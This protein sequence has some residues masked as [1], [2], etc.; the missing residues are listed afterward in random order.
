MKSRVQGAPTAAVWLV[1]LFASDRQLESICGDLS[2]EFSDRLAR[3]GSAAAR[4]WYW[5]QSI[6]T[7]GDLIVAGLR[8]SPVLITLSVLA[9]LA[10]LGFSIPMPERIIDAVIHYFQHGVISAPSN[11]DLFWLNTGILAGRFLVAVLVGGMIAWISAGKEVIVGLSLG[12]IWALATTIA[13]GSWIIRFWPGTTI[14]L[15]LAEW[16]IEKNLLLIA[17]AVVTGSIIVRVCR[18]SRTGPGVLSRNT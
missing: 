17:A 2:E 9:G 14:A 15:A 11:L 8:D 18:V 6:R 1:E 13:L 10:L 7:V 16:A 4:R 12:T 5:R 3:S